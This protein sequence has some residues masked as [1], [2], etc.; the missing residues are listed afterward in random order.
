MKKR[1]I[2]LP[3]EPQ[4]KRAERIR[5][6]TDF[7]FRL[8]A[9]KA[10][11]LT[12][13]PFKLERTGRQNN[14]MW[15]PIYGPFSAFTGYTEAEL[16]DTMLKLFFGE[17]TYEVLGIVQKKPRR[18]TTTNEKGERDVLSRERMAEFIEFIFQKAAEL[19]LYIEAP[20]PMLRTRAA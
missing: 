9:D 16:H 6:V 5:R 8:P 17:V 7:L 4:E 12:V 2:I 15:G 11:E 13:E 19:G 14:A 18:T 20:N 1:P 3:V 10:W